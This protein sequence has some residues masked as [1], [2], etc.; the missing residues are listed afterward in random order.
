METTRAPSS[1]GYFVHPSAFW[2]GSAAVSLGVLF[3]LPQFIDSRSEGY[4][5]SALGMSPLMVTG[6]LLILAGFGLVYYGVSPRYLHPA[7]ESHLQVKGL[8]DAPLRPAH[9]RLM[10]V[11]LVAI[12]VDTLKP[13]TFPFIIPGA[14]AEYGLTS[15]GHPGGLPIALYPFS[16]ILGTAIGS[17][18]WGYLGDRIGRRA[19]ILFSAII[20]I[21]TSICGF[22]PSYGWNL[23]MCFVMGLGVGGLLPIAYSLLAETIP[24][25]S[26]GMIVV[27]VAG[28]GTALGFLIAS[29]AADWLVPTYSWRIMWFLGLPSGLVLIVANHWIPESARF[30]LAN[31]REA[32]ARAA[33]AEFGVEI[34]ETSGEDVT[35]EI[36]HGLGRVDLTRLFRTPFTGLTTAIVIY[37]LAWGLV[38][39]G[40]LVWLPI[41]LTAQGLSETHV[42][43]VLS[44]AALFA[45]PGAVV[46]A[47]L[48]GRWSAKKTMVLVAGT[49]AM[50]LFVL[51][52]G[53]KGLVSHSA[54]LSVLLVVLLVSLWGVVSVLAPYAAEVYPTTIRASGSGVAA[55]A[56]KVGGVAVLAMSVAAIAPPSIA[57]AA[58]L[59]GVP[60]LAAAVGIGAAGIE[61]RGRSLE[62]ISLGELEPSAD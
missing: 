11:L 43:A 35:S 44:H 8:D 41:K 25:R 30:L 37:G 34:V 3:H 49:C 50:V 16:G 14:T 23:F 1:K 33:M 58:I 52:V 21:G 42:A 10:A 45:V 24:A 19:T 47:W 15:A 36:S 28:V 53:G 5:V 29:G 51:A 46:V 17:F 13:F 4:R 38:N 22:M 60:M 40:F 26:R 31:G 20:F 12:A 54:L 7:S 48:Y 6:M 27:L 18:I 2:A 9:Y 39:F 59:T 57:G 32:E 56:T 61:T 62:A 55:G